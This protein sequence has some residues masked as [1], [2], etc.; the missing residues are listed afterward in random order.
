MQHHLHIYFSHVVIS[1]MILSPP[2]HVNDR[3]FWGCSS[4]THPLSPVPSEP[5]YLWNVSNRCFLEQC[6]AVPVPTSLKLVA[7][8]QFT[9]Q[10]KQKWMKWNT[11]NIIFAL[12]S[13]ECISETIVKWSHS[14]LFN[15]LHSIPKLWEYFWVILKATPLN[16]HF[17]WL[18]LINAL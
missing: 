9:K 15:F 11:E 7:A 16:W 5:V 6:F 2:L 4:H 8:I 3:A 10:A 14:F 13:I 1:F 12:L 18:C 17:S